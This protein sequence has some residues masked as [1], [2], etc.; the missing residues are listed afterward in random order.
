MKLQKGDRAM[1]PIRFPSVAAIG[2]AY[3][4]SS[5]ARE[6]ALRTARRLAGAAVCLRSESVV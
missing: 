4:I 3:L 5:S 2:H 1:E 6:D